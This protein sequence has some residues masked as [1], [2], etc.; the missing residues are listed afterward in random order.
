MMLTLRSIPCPS[1]T[2]WVRSSRAAIAARSRRRDQ[3]AE[4]RSARVECSSGGL[5]PAIAVLEQSD[6]TFD[7]IVKLRVYTTHPARNATTRA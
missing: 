4:P 7:S 5:G 2:P 3:T 6:A 1:L